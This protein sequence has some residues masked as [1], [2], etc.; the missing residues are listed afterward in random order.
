[1][2]DQQTDL[3][4]PENGKKS[5]R[6]TETAIQKHEPQMV[7]RL[8]PKPTMEEVLIQAVQQGASIET[9]E[10]IGAMIERAN[11]IAAERQFNEALS[12]FQEVMPVIA[13]QKRVKDK[14]GGD[15]FFYAPIEDIL[16]VARPHLAENG[17]AVNTGGRVER[18]GNDNFYI[19][20]AYLKH[21]GG[22]VEKCEFPVP[23]VLSQYMSDPQSYA[24]ASTFAERYAIRK[25]CGIVTAGDDNEGR[26]T[27][28]QAR[29]ARAA[30]KMPTATPTA[31]KASQKGN[32]ASVRKDLEPT[33]DPAEAI[34]EEI[35][36]GLAL[37]MK[38]ATLGMSDLQKRFP[39]LT[40]LGEIRQADVQVVMSWIADPV[41]N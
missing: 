32:G 4:P 23:I 1:M 14:N 25:V 33:D 26:L 20:I 18:I 38:H 22:H 11:A 31:Q 35:G 37:A 21:V 16:P 39:K 8:Q 24:S 5:K 7:E 2:T 10:R 9:I 40:R 12:K 13:K 29:D 28:N 15:R 17:L 19:G 34:P 41:R 6:K 36:K 3:L 27:P 30:V